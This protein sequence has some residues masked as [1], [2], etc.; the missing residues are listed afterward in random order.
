[1]V[2]LQVGDVLESRYRIDHPI[3]RGGMSTVFRCV[4][5]RLGRPVAAKVMDERYVNDSV[6]RQRFRREARAMAQLSH[7]NL[8][9]VYD[10]GSDGDHLYLVMELIRGGTLRELLAERGPMPPHAATAVVRNVLTG[11]SVAHSAGMVHRDIKPDNVLINDNHQ[12]K[13][14]DFGLVRAASRDVSGTDKIV[15]TV[16]YLSPEQVEG[17]EIDSASDVYSAGILLFEL[18][19]GT[20]PFSGDTDLAH[21]Y[22]RLNN[23]VPPPSSRIAGVP[24]LFD[25]LV[26]TA[27][28][29][30]AGDRFADAGEFLAALDDI[31]A[32]LALPSFKVPVPR[33]AAAHRAAAVPTDTSGI[34]GPLEPT[35]IIDPE[36]RTETIDSD[37]EP[38]ESLYQEEPGPGPDETSVLPPVVAG[39]QETAVF[40]TGGAEEESPEEEPPERRPET[41]VEEGVDAEEPR[42]S[43]STPVSN[44]SRTKLVV[45]LVVVALLTAAIAVGGWWFGSGRY[46]EIPQVLGMEQTAAAGALEA[47]GYPTDTREVYSNEVPEDEIAGTEPNAGERVVRGDTV[48]MLV[49]LG[50]PTVPA[51]PQN[52][53]VDTL[54]ERLGERELSLE[55]GEPTYSD[56]VAEGGVVRTDP[57]PGT[58][59]PTGSTVTAHLSRGP[60]PVS[61]PDV[62]GLSSGSARDELEQAGLSVSEVVE[63]FDGETPGGEAIGTQPAAGETVSRGTPI[64]LRISNAL[65]VPD[66]TGLSRDE[67]VQELSEAGLSIGSENRDPDEVADAADEIIAVE[68]QAGEL[69]DPANPVVSVTLPG[70]VE[71]PGVLGRRVSDARQML[72]DAGLSVQTDD[73]GDARVY[74]QS[75]GSGDEVPPGTEIELSAIG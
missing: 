9:N 4:D 30:H 60:A 48:T 47:A 58:T 42:P 34:I 21:A 13:L 31:A 71:V 74:R 56:S 5:L 54:R 1:M 67:A 53:N 66:I 49:S 44:R 55:T 22:Q 12:V 46:G 59:V 6:F 72:E 52:R 68:P 73:S 10:F 51:I 14:A 35:G 3:A 28:A 39:P 69:I 70:E 32:E 18:L 7:P 24:Q 65:E 36:D 43:G 63:V 45:W 75:P 29:R 37:D 50:Q 20:T 57:A 41:R 8:L 15:G 38:T 61:V 19:T 16:A 2:Q 27:T 11:L 40:P 26:G 23:P 62:E 25:E 64:T 17:T 33:N